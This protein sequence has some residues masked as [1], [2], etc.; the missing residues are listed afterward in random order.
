[1]KNYQKL[2]HIFDKNMKANCRYMA[3]ED[4]LNIY[5]FD[6]LMYVIEKLKMRYH[7]IQMIIPHYDSI[8]ELK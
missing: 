1:M 2:E 5:S 6:D 7:K 3:K 4:S 8:D